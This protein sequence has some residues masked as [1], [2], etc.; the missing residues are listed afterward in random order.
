MNSWDSMKTFLMA[1]TIFIALLIIS[2]IIS[3]FVYDS[4][5]F[6][7][8]VIEIAYDN[9]GGF[10]G[11]STHSIVSFDDGSVFQFDSSL[12]KELREGHTYILEYRTPYFMGSD[13]LA[14]LRELVK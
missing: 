11:S 13:S 3:Y 1:M 8:T 12:P 7:A 10:L 6:E 9:T 5:E 4:Y 14:I 2:T